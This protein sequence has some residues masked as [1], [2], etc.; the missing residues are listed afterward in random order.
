MSKISNMFLKPGKV[1]YIIR[2]PWDFKKWNFFLPKLKNA[3][4]DRHNFNFFFLHLFQVD[5]RCHIQSLY[6]YHENLSGEKRLI[7]TA[8]NSTEPYMYTINRASDLHRGRYFCIINN[9]M[10]QNECSAHLVLQNSGQKPKFKI[11]VFIMSALG[12][13]L[14]CYWKWCY[15]F[16]QSQDSFFW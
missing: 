7:Q 11:S 14:L 4:Y 9:V 3:F 16:L 10:G 13:L 1:L 5:V 2:F 15:I 8:R 12:L 6:W